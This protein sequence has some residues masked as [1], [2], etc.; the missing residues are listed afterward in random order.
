MFSVNRN[1]IIL[2]NK[3]F[4]LSQMGFALYCDY[5]MCNRTDGNFPLD[6][7]IDIDILS[8]LPGGSNIF[9]NLLSPNYQ[10]ILDITLDCIKNTNKKY[11]FFIMYE[12]IIPIIFIDKLLPYTIDMF[13]NNNVYYHPQIHVLPIG[14]RDGEDVFIEHLYFKE[15]F[16]LNESKT[17]KIKKH[18]CLLCFSYNHEERIKCEDV[19]GNKDFVLNLNRFDYTPQPSIHCGKVPVWVNY[20][21]THESIFVLSPSGLGEDTHRFY[22][23]IFLDAIPIVKRTFTAFDKL[24][25]FFPCL[26]VNNWNEITEDFLLKNMDCS[27]QKLKLFKEKYPNL[28]TNLENIEEVLLN[29]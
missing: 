20:E 8:N 24:Y 10:S 29:L 25:N 16:L 15:Q 7:D 13:I 1:S 5:Y 23:A 12:P 18:L 4:G 26:I 14:I 11:N 17:Q 6:A 27:I 22:E 19:L 2:Q 3:I 21:K 9:M 28:Y